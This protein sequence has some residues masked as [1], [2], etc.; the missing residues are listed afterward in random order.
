MT[1][2][3][4]LDDKEEALARSRERAASKWALFFIP[5]LTTI[6]A[7]MVYFGY[8]MF[9]EGD[10]GWKIV[11][12]GQ[13]YTTLAFTLVVIAGL[14]YTWYEPEIVALHHG[15]TMFYFFFALW[16]C[17]AHIVFV[18]AP[19]APDPD[20]T[21]FDHLGFSCYIFLMC[22]SSQC[23][24]IGSLCLRQ[25]LFY[26][27]FYKNELNPSFWI[28]VPVFLAICI[29]IAVP[30]V[31][32]GYADCNRFVP[33]STHFPQM[34]VMACAFFYYLYYTYHASR[35]FVS[36]WQNVRAFVIHNLLQIAFFVVYLTAACD[37]FV[38]E[39]L[40]SLY[41]VWLVGLDSFTIPL[42]R[43]IA[44][45]AFGITL[46]GDIDFHGAPLR[47]IKNEDELDVVIANKGY[48]RPALQAFADGRYCGENISFLSELYDLQEKQDLGHWT[49]DDT[50]QFQRIIVEY[51]DADG[52]LSLN[53]TVS[54]REDCL[55][56][57]ADGEGINSTFEKVLKAIK[58]LTTLNLWNTFVDTPEYKEALRKS[59]KAEEN[60]DNVQNNLKT[61][62]LLPD[63]ERLANGKTSIVGSINGSVFDPSD[64]DQKK[65]PSKEKLNRCLSSARNLEQDRNA[66]AVS[67][68]SSTTLRD[69]AD[70]DRYYSEEPTQV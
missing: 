16:T 40:I 60:K 20:G 5:I 65:D 9:A 17:S 64:R 12:L 38:L 13:A 42:V 33:R 15:F 25:R 6:W 22:F 48:F 51:I 30:F 27:I 62:G 18:E 44:R 39:T 1:S 8:S 52:S 31:T 7:V 63:H 34:F 4:I 58:F 21:W 59:N 32:C 57:H 14:A 29:T 67:I 68:G 28:A 37:L 55:K 43:A 46:W 50:N 41:F 24:L 61:A 66:T 47:L 36:F 45:K 3:F 56:K 53:L 19:I 26:Y 54:V 10:E 11:Q 2:S 49:T 70:G 35:V 23:T 69:Y